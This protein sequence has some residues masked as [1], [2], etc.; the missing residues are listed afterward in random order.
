MS[1]DSPS[2]SGGSGGNWF[3]NMAGDIQSS[4]GLG[5]GGLSGWFNG[6]SGVVTG[7]ADRNAG[8]DVSNAL[9]P[10]S[11][12]AA[13]A[14]PAPPSAASVRQGQITQ[15]LSS[16]QQ[17]YAAS[18]ILNGGQGLTDEPTTASRVLLGS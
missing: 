14:P 9:S 11:T 8:N 6:V 7:G 15:G 12:P 2:P 18:T 16:E 5:G 3:N 10:P 4:G 17:M 13:Q 1:S